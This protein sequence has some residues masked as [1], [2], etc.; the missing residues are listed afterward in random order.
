MLGWVVAE[1]ED[2][3]SAEAVV[4]AGVEDAVA[5]SAVVLGW[6]LLSVVGGSSLSAIGAL[7]PFASPS[8]LEEAARDNPSA[9]T[10]IALCSHNDRRDKVQRERRVCAQLQWRHGKSQAEADRATND[11]GDMKL[12]AMHSASVQ[13]TDTSYIGTSHAL[14]TPT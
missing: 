9:S 4:S 8:A 3:V 11:A 13:P 6:P 1:G 12:A 10:G 7:G 2:E 14:V 5:V